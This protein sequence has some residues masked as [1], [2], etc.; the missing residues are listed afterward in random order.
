MDS[1]NRNED[2]TRG[3]EDKFVEIKPDEDA[4]YERII[5]I[6]A[7][8]IKHTI[9]CPHT[10]DNT[11]TIDELGKIK[12]NQVFVGTC[13]NGRIEDLRVVA[14]IL[15]GK[16]VH[17]DVRLLIAPAS[18]DVFK[19]ALQEGLIETF[20]DAN[21]AILTSGCG[22]C[23]G[24]HAGI[25]GDGETCLATQNRNFQGRMGNTQGFIYLI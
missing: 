3:R 6:D 21:A 1:N 2:K 15:K 5:K 13:T 16:T 9:S 12:V 11:K 24:V 20:V 17:S 14:N 22:P 10:V 19:Q 7:S 18:K 25:L 4:Q 8:Q 23:V